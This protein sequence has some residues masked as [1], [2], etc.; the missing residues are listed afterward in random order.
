[1]TSR[2]KKKFDCCNLDCPHCKVAGDGWDAVAVCE[3]H[4]MVLR[5]P[6]IAGTDLWRRCEG[7]SEPIIREVIDKII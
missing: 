5:R 6:P 4:K 3:K 7:C 1:M 2:E